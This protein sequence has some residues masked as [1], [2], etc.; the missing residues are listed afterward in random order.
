MFEHFDVLYENL[1]QHLS[2]T[3]N[4][5][6]F[7]GQLSD[8][9]DGE[10][11]ADAVA[12]DNPQCFIVSKPK[13]SPTKKAIIINDW[14]SIEDKQQK[15]FKLQDF[16]DYLQ[17]K[18]HKIYVRDPD[19]PCFKLLARFTAYS[20]LFANLFQFFSPTHS[21]KYRQPIPVCFANGSCAIR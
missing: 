13:A 20:V 19:K 9:D 17:L 16:I 15:G 7:Q 3:Y 6:E 14:I 5:P 1:N 2:L 11:D 12:S 10:I 18:G 4:D 21:S 8:D